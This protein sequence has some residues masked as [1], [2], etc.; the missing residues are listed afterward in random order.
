M[1]TPRERVMQALTFQSVDHVPLDLGGMR[2]TSISAFAYPK[3]VAALGLPPRRPRIEDTGQMLALPDL[4]VLDALGCDVVTIRDGVTNALDQ[5]GIWYDYDFN[6][7]LPARVRN[8]AGFQTLPDGTL[9][10]GS[11]RMVPDS[12]VFDAPHGGQPLDLSAELPRPDLTQ[13]RTDLR[14]RELP[15]AQII[16]IAELCR[17]V[18]GATDRAIFFNDGAI[19]DGI[20]IGSHG[21]L[22]IFPMLCLL[23]PEYVAELHEILTAHTLKNLRALLPEIRDNVDLLM[24]SADDWGTQSN[25][26]ASPQVYRELFLPYRQRINTTIDELAPKV[27]RFLHSCGAIYKLIDLIIESGYDVL[28]PIQWSAGGQNYRAWKDKA[29]KRIALWGGGVNSQVTLPLGSV[30]AVAREVRDVVA[31]L[32]A[33]SGY[34]FCNIHNIL[35]EIEPE[36]V[37]AMYRTAATVT[38]T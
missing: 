3:L 22:A 2:S 7:R 18:R 15:D 17:R 21:G 4:D 27:K 6:G 10:Q 16:A 28:N 35:A 25:L 37:I 30:D 34:I 24:L 31:Y 38:V 12:Y 26:I 1:T 11:R 33:D 20:G 8:P 32:A 9:L 14:M 5:P 23:E 19:S 36:K 29:R 13:L